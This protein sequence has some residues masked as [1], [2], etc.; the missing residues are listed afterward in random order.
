MVKK[1]HVCYVDEKGWSY[2]LH[3]YSDDSEAE[4]E[5]AILNTE[6]TK[7]P[8]KLEPSRK[9]IKD[10]YDVFKRD[11]VIYMRPVVGA[12]CIF[13]IYFMV[14][15]GDDGYLVP[16]YKTEDVVRAYCEK[17]NNEKSDS[18][19]LI[20]YGYHGSYTKHEKFWRDQPIKT[21]ITWLSWSAT[22]KINSFC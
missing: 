2:F 13:S 19:V 20:Y 9:W 12:R 16:A 15:G 17:Q 5:C 7:F 10:R 6:K 22:Q 21:P 4:A 14:E 18:P 1:S 3:E 11:S 8:W